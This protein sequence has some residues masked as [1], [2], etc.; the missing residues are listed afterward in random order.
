M[1]HQRNDSFLIHRF[2]RSKLCESC[3]NLPT[4]FDTVIEIGSAIVLA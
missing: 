4:H 3:W 1:V 2:L